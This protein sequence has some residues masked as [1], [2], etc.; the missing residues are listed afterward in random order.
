MDFD[1][2]IIKKLSPFKINNLFC[3]IIIININSTH[4][5]NFKLKIKIL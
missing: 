4:Y 2:I 3:E 1:F 5:L